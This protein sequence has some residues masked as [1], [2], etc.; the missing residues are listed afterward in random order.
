MRR[1]LPWLAWAGYF[2]CVAGLVL[3][4][5]AVVAAIIG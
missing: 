2:A 4:G 1:A 3:V 5:L